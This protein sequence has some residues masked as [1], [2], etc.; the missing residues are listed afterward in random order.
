MC[1]YHYAYAPQ[2]RDEEST[3]GHEGI[4]GWRPDRP[5]GI[6]RQFRALRAKCNITFLRNPCSP[7]DPARVLLADAQ[8]GPC[9]LHEAYRHAAFDASRSGGASASGGRVT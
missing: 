8:G 1:Y 4:R 2:T 5:I 3:E 9:G 6:A 7:I